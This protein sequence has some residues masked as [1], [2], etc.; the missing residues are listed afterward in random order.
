MPTAVEQVLA[1]TAGIPGIYWMGGERLPKRLKYK[2]IVFHSTLGI[3]KQVNKKLRWKSTQ[4]YLLIWPQVVSH[5]PSHFLSVL[6][7]KPTSSS[8]RSVAFQSLQDRTDCFLIFWQISTC[9][10]QKACTGRPSFQL[11]PMLS[12]NVNRLSN[13]TTQ[14]WID[15][16]VHETVFAL[17]EQIHW[18]GTRAAG[19]SCRCWH[20]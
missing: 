16:I 10:T 4:L 18:C 12:W 5:L 19:C 2:Q 17:R 15:A 6:S 20:L 14:F 8:E 1:N 7:N 11:F 9:F 13:F 3:Q